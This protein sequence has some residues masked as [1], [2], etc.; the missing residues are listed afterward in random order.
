MRKSGTAETMVM[1]VTP[2]KTMKRISTVK[3]HGS[4][5]HHRGREG[6]DIGW[7]R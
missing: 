7:L 4:P 6:K 5:C 2:A 1:T 3:C